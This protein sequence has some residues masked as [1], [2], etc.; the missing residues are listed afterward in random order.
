MAASASETVTDSPDKP[1][2][3]VYPPPPSNAP[4]PLYARVPIVASIAAGSA[5]ACAAAPT[6]E[7]RKPPAASA[8]ED[9]GEVAYRAPCST[10]AAEASAS[11]AGCAQGA[12]AHVFASKTGFSAHTPMGEGAVGSEDAPLAEMVSSPYSRRHTTG[13]V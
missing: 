13:A 10:G 1:T 8:A 9:R 4:L 3:D 12:L 7:A 6:E 2:D 5:K 11:A